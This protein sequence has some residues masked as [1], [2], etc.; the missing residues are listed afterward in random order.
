MRLTA[1]LPPLNNEIMWTP[2]LLRIVITRLQYGFITIE[3]YTL[4]HP[5]RRDTI[6]SNVLN[7]S[8]A[9]VHSQQPPLYMAHVAPTF[10][11]THTKIRTRASLTAQ[12]SRSSAVTQGYTHA[13]SA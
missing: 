3:T 4:Q 13:T 11:H 2:L 5:I 7:Y 8:M 1:E 12:V 6:N 9:R 10:L